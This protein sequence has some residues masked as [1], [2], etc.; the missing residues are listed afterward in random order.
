MKVRR[1]QR[2]MIHFILRRYSRSPRRGYQYWAL[3]TSAKGFLPSFSILA[4]F[5]TCYRFPK[6]VTYLIF[7][8]GARTPSLQMLHWVTWVKLKKTT[9]TSTLSF[10]RAFPS[11]DPGVLLKK[12]EDSYPN[13]M[14]GS[15]FEPPP[16]FFCSFFSI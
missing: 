3:L 15:Y 11:V 10:S 6:M 1:W 9:D 13:G 5:G 16:L 14:S 4:I 12:N 2:L 7:I 8:T